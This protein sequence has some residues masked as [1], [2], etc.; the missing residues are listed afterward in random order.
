MT[1]VT[2]KVSLSVVAPVTSK[3]LESVVS[4]VT[5][6]VLESVVTPVT[7]K[8]SLSVVAPVT[9]K[10]L[11]SVVSPVTSKVSL[12]VVAP[13]TSKVLESVV[14]P[15]TFKVSLSVVEPVTSKVSLSV[16][17]PVTSK[18]LE[19]VVTPVTFKVESKST[20]PV[21]WR[22]PVI[23]K[24]DCGLLFS[25]P[26]LDILKISSEIP[27]KDH[28]SEIDIFAKLLL[29]PTTALTRLLGSLPSKK[30]KFETVPIKPPSS[31]IPIVCNGVPTPE[32]SPQK[33]LLLSLKRTCPIVPGFA[34]LSWRA[35]LRRISSSNVEIPEIK[36]VP[37]TVRFD[38]GVVL[39]I[40][41]LS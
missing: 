24:V 20:A 16:V 29:S 1:P 19:S 8:V 17:A 2:F 13:V 26:T 18:V 10:V 7:F 32:T 41:T 23:S 33:T 31:Y 40:P 5:S 12:S 22:V 30:F 34:N 14:T 37:F 3:V 25:I 35:P 38:V 11:E 39:P 4:P 9:S 21:A 36:T 6:K 28:L 27:V 15:V